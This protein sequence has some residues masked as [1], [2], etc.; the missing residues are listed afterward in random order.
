[1]KIYVV[2]EEWY[3]GPV[4]GML[5]RIIAVYTSRELAE[6]KARLV[7]A[8]DD[9]VRIVVLEYEDDGYIHFGIA[10]PVELEVG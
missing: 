4:L 7:K 3:A 8:T 10:E 6:E 1:M 2:A 9:D 5:H